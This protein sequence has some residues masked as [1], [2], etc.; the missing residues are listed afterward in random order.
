MAESNEEM[1]LVSK[2]RLEALEALEKKQLEYY[3]KLRQK[4][5]ENP[6]AHAKEALERYHKNKETIN[7][8]RRELYKKKKEAEKNQA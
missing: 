7:A 5:Q 3:T 6:E 4:Q 1:V 2:K 8:R